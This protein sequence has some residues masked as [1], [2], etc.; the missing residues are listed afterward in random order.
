[1]SAWWRS[2][3]GCSC[4]RRTGSACTRGHSAAE[5]YGGANGAKACGR[6]ELSW[7]RLF[8]VWSGTPCCAAA[9]SDWAP[10]AHSRRLRSSPQF[11]GVTPRRRRLADGR[12]I[13]F[14]LFNVAAEPFVFILKV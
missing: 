5:R 9:E 2:P 6:G 8:L 1:R 4:E 7:P 13:A 11:S 10:G 3:F 14:H 12:R